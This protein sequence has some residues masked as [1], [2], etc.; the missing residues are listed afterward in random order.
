MNK[1]DLNSDLFWYAL[2][3]KVGYEK[4]IAAALLAKA[5]KLNINDIETSV[6]TDLVNNRH[7]VRYPGIVLIKT[8]DLNSENEFISGIAG[9]ER[10]I[11][12]SPISNDEYDFMS[13]SVI[14]PVA[15]E[16]LVGGKVEIISGAF[17]TQVMIVREIDGDNVKGLLNIFE[18]E[19]EVVINKND[20][21]AL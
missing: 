18:R 9:V 13:K 4:K 17:V 5:A 16:I 6:F 14:L 1:T 12:R 15:K 21:L 2:K 8:D 10:F 19:T 7:V 20:L 3:V 11:S